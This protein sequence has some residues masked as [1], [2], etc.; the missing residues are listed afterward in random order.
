MGY[1]AH[2]SWTSGN[3]WSQQ[4]ERDIALDNIKCENGYWDSC[5]YT[6]KHNCGHSED[7]FLHCTD[8]GKLA[9]SFALKY[10]NDHKC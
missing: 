5:T 1:F 10:L 7:V 2:V 3:K 4:S 9:T 8:A 6:T